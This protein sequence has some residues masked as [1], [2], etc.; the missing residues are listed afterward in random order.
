MTSKIFIVGLLF[1]TCF[2]AV[3]QSTAN[4]P[5]E[6]KAFSTFFTAEKKW[7]V[8][9]VKN[10]AAKRNVELW[11][12]GELVRWFDIELAESKADWFAYLDLSKWK[13]TQIDLRIDK[14]TVGSKVFSPVQQSDDDNNR[15]TLYKEKQRGQIH[16]SPKRG[17]TNDPNGLVYFNGEYHLFFQHNPYG[18]LWG[19]MHWGHAVSK[20]LIHWKEIDIALYPD[21]FGPVFSGGAVV[22][23]K[24]SNMLSTSQQPVMAMFATGAKSWGQTLAWSKDGRNFERYDTSILHR[25]TIGNRDPKVIW[26]EP[27]K[28]W[29]MVLY[30]TEDEPE[31]SHTMHFFTSDNLKAWTFASKITGGAGN[32]RYMFECP[33][34]FEL[35]VTGNESQ[36]KWILTAANSQY[37]IGTFDGKV[38]TPELERL[39]G[40]VGRGYY[41]AQT[42]S[43]EP[44]GRRVEI[45]WWWTHTEKAGMNFNQS[46]TIPMEL[47]LVN[48]DSGLRV[49]RTPI[50]EM[51]SLRRQTYKIGNFRLKDNVPHPLDQVSAQQ[52]EFRFTLEPA[53]ASQV[54]IDIHGTPVIYHVASQEL[55]V[56]GVKAFAPLKKG[57]LDLIIYVDR[58]GLEIFSA[59]GLFYMPVNINMNT[60]QQKFAFTAKGGQAKA[61]NVII[62]DL[63]SIW[64]GN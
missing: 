29:V 43:D 41:A 15:D 6:E 3:S 48:T 11:V 51:Q 28:K 16:F 32:D 9:P 22:D 24:N 52:A 33:E 1:T 40:N 63:K 14:L 53:T 4:A 61:S 39:N 56:D 46:H 10:G 30:V 5:A 42:V 23:P 7:L 13:G 62:Y 38:F 21:K 64:E 19:N 27:T 35:P 37:A 47:K 44:K 59:D 49:T 34:F 8:L 60:D 25:I 58:I 54:T 26:H 45:G 31:E 20:D 50:A 57:K 55:E 36:K 12:G 17:W 18:V 2:Q